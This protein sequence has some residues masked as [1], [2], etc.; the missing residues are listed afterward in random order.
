MKDSLL[1]QL[2]SQAQTVFT[3]DELSQLFPNINYKNLKDRLYYFTKVGKLKRPHRGVYAKN[4]Y[5]SF[6]LGNKIYTP[7]YISLETVL[8][9]AGVVFQH[10]ETTFLVSHL[11]RTLLIQGLN[12][13]Y[14]KMP[15]F[16]LTNKLGIEEKVGYFIAT[17]ERAF[18]D[19]VYIYKNYHFDNLGILDW[20]KVDNLKGIYKSKVLKKRVT[21]YFKSYQEEYAKH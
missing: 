17:P 8:K 4:G 7:S 10:Y 12:I 1:L 20:S 16:I 2:Y 3:M 5:D 14:R 9:K 15:N 21:D 13:Q 19:A 18:L 11:T 6:E